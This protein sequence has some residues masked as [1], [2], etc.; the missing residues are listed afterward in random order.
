[1]IGARLTNFSFAA[2]ATNGVDDVRDV[3]THYS[4]Y[5]DPLEAF[6][7]A[8]TRMQ[9]RNSLKLAYRFVTRPDSHVGS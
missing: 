1:M 8:Q 9:V 4:H 5:N 2:I 3:L 6:K 7:L